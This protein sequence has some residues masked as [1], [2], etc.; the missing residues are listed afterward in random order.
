MQTVIEFRRS[1]ERIDRPDGPC[2]CCSD[3]PPGDSDG[4]Q[5]GNTGSIGG[6]GDTD[7]ILSSRMAVESVVGAA[8]G[9][10]AVIMSGHPRRC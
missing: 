1:P 7:S 8:T 6:Q 5:I 9:I 10:T 3:W 4:K 2:M